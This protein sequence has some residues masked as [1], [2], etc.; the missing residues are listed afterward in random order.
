MSTPPADLHLPAVHL[1]PPR[2]WINDPN[3]LVF[4]DGHYH[5]FFQYNPYGPWH[6]NVHWGHYRSPD[7]IN[8]EPLP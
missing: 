3:G 7:L 2:N 5:V 4:H 1:R 8:W 6:S